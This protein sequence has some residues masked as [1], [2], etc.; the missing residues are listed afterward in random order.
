MRVDVQAGDT[1]WRVWFN[2]YE[3]SAI[4]C[5]ADSDEGWA[6]IVVLYKQSDKTLWGVPT[7]LDN[8]DTAPLVARINGRIRIEDK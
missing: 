7:D 2:G 3:I 8:D 1:N 4:C 6:D 5:A